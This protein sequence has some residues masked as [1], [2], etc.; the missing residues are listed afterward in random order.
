MLA[1]DGINQV[2]LDAQNGIKGSNVSDE[3]SYNWRDYGHLHLLAISSYIMSLE[4][5]DIINLNSQH[6]ASPCKDV[7][8]AHHQ[9]HYGSCP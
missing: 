3:I 7:L 2:S 1:A 5:N 4:M 8:G 6:M 9:N